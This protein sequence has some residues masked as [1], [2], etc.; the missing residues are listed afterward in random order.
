MTCNDAEP[1]IARFADDESSLPAGVRG[2]LVSHVAACAACRAALDGQRD[3]AELLRARPASTPRPGLVARVSAR[4]DN[5]GGRAAEDGW[6]GLANW[7]G[8]TAALVPL[9]AT[10][11]VA[12]YMDLGRAA[13]TVSNAVAPT[14]DELTIG[15]VPAILQP[16]A[17]GDALMEA[18]LTGAAPSSGDVDVR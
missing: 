8:W 11:L 6:L 4:L 16:S 2:E 17:T 3:V 14:F 13:T 15:D 5:E 12:A 7:R 1:L 10:L 9:A 18:V